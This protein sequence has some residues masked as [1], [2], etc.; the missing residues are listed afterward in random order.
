MS[1]KILLFSYFVLMMIVLFGCGISAQSGGDPLPFM[2]FVQISLDETKINEATPITLHANYGYDTLQTADELGLIKHTIK[3]FLL[4]GNSTSIDSEEDS[5]LLYEIEYTGDDLLSDEYACDS[6]KWLWSDV[7]YNM[8]VDIDID[9]ST[10]EFD[11]G[12]V[13]I[14]FVEDYLSQNNIDGEIIETEETQYT[15]TYFYFM[16]TDGK[17]EFST[18]SFG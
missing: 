1:K 10:V 2:G 8:S 11:S 18:R 9:F 3:V 4:D 16:K 7:D 15:S 5:V 17:V 13:V 12:L 6:G 14:K